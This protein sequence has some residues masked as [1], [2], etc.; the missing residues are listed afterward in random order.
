MPTPGI[1]CKNDVPLSSQSEYRV[2]IVNVIMTTTMINN[3]TE[4]ILLALAETFGCF[5]RRKSILVIIAILFR[6]HIEPS[7]SNGAGI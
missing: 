7:V 6:W 4:K 3:K 5:F 2:M 1:A